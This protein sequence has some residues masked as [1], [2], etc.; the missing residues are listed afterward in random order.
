[1]LIHYDCKL[2]K[3]HLFLSSLS[4]TLQFEGND[5]LPGFD[6]VGQKDLLWEALFHV[7]QNVQVFALHVRHKCGFEAFKRQNIH[8]IHH[9]YAAKLPVHINEVE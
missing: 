6:I 5:E 3:N 8:F 1:M 9:T 7:R 4:L 2:L